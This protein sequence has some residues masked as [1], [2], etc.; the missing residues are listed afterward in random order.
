MG[1]YVL[2]TDCS[3]TG[4]HDFGDLKQCIFTILLS[5]GQQTGPGLAGFSASGHKAA[6]MV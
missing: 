2:V 4:S 3:V 5:M 6:I 1:M